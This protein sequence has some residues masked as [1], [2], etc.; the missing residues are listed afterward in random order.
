MIPAKVS[1]DQL[2]FNGVSAAS[3]IEGAV[4]ASGVLITDLNPDP[5]YQPLLADFSG[6]SGISA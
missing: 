6:T 2:F 3:G 1:A 4:S 5:I